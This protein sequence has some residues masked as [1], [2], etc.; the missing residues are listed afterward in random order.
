VAAG[1]PQPSHA[2][3]LANGRPLV[4]APLS[5]LPSNPIHRADNLM[6]GNEGQFLPWEIALDNVQI[7]PA[8]G[9]AMDPNSHLARSGHGTGRLDK[10]Q[11][12]GVYRR[13]AA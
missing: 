5:L 1:V 12:R 13:Q 2:H 11:R 9:A 6:A 10:F 8:N 3:P 7:G 4:P